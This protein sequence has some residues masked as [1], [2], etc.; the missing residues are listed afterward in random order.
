MIDQLDVVSH[1]DPAD[2]PAWL[3]HRRRRE[4]VEEAT[5]CPHGLAIDLCGERCGPEPPPDPS[6]GIDDA[7]CSG[8]AGPTTR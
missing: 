5:R 7:A 2:D 6:G 1:T 4:A 8:C 3:E